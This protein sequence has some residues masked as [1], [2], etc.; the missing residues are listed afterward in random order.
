[1]A[2]HRL[3]CQ[4]KVRFAWGS[5]GPLETMHKGHREE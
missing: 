2:C 5:R 4:L 3:T 1:M